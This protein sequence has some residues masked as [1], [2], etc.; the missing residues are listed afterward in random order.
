MQQEANVHPYELRAQPSKALLQ[1]LYRDVRAL[2]A[3]EV[4]LAKLEVHERLKTGYR[5]VSGVALSVGLALIA[6]G[7]FAACAIAALAL[8]TGLWLA[9]LIVGA[10][11]GVA[12]FAFARWARQQ[13][14]EAAEPLRSMV[15]KF[16][17]PSS[18]GLTAGELESRIESTRRHLDETLSALE[19]KTDLVVPMRDTAL[20]LGSLGIA[21][22]AIVRG[23]RENR[24]D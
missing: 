23:D 5:A 8:T 17:G 14:A 16:V 21:V 18:A 1:R 6:L 7:C 3:E 22:S 12:A 19:H 20:G 4:E 9:A 13:F 11:V 2:I 15:G 10:I 24:E